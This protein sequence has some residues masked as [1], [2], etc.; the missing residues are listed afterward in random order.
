MMRYDTYGWNIHTVRVTFLDE[1]GYLGSATMKIRGNIEG[2][3]VLTNV[4]GSFED[5]MYEGDIVLRNSEGHEIL[6]DPEDAAIYMVAVQIVGVEP[7]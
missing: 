2:S 5:G 3:S 1:G 6:L 4:I 7:E